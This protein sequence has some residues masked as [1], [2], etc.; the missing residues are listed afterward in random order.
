MSKWKMLRGDARRRLAGVGSGT[1][2]CCVTSPPYFGLRDYGIEGQ[3]GR[4]KAVDAYVSSLISVFEQVRRVLRDDGVFF[5]NL[6]DSYAANRSYQVP[7]TKGGKKHGP[8]QS[9]PGSEVPVGLKPKDLIGIPWTVAFAVRAAGWWLRQEIIWEKPDAM[10]YPAK[11]RCV[12][13]HE[14]IFLFSKKPRYHFDY[15][16]IREPAVTGKWDS[17]PPIGGKKHTAKGDNATYTGNRPA[18]DGLRNKRDVWTVSTSRSKQSHCAVFPSKLIEPMILAGC[19]VGGTV[20]DPFAGTGTTGVVSI[21]LG[22]RFVG[23]ELNPEY[24]KLACT[25]LRKAVESTCKPS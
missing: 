4:E 11:D 24:H 17:M 15:K 22:R 19:P 25:N 14:H 5:L 13:S 20:L 2:Q 12:S 18:G 7:S 16:S 8:A 23:I 9:L 6:G 21:G 10:P 1:I 3:I